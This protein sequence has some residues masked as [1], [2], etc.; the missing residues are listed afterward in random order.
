MDKKRFIVDSIEF[1]INFKLIA[2]M[3]GLVAKKFHS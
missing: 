1:Q 3:H 2:K